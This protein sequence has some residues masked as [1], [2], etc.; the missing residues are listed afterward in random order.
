MKENGAGLILFGL[1]MLGLMV[2][3]AA[4]DV[5]TAI[6][7]A[8]SESD[9]RQAISANI[10]EGAIHSQ[11]YRLEQKC[12]TFTV[13]SKNTDVGIGAPTSKVP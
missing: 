4:C 3:L 12:P 5:A 10:I 9:Y 6:R 2:R 11:T 7:S 8:S 13:D 1:A